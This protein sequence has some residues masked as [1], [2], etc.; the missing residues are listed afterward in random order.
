MG[1]GTVLEEVWDDE[2]QEQKERYVNKSRSAGLAVQAVAHADPVP[3]GPEQSVKE[4][5]PKLDQRIYKRLLEVRLSRAFLTPSCSKSAQ[6]GYAMRC[7]RS[8]TR[9]T[10]TRLRSEFGPYSTCCIHCR[11]RVTPHL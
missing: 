6:F 8:L 10:A 9:G 3:K 5:I 11:P 1:P 7:S 2:A 4:R